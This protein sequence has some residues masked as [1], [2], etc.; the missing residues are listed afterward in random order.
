MHAP[1]LQVL[2]EK[3]QRLPLVPVMPEEPVLPLS[4]EAYHTLLKAGVLEDGDP[5]E[6]LEGF[7]V[8]K[9]TKGAHHAAIKRRF[10]RLINPFVPA[11]CFVDTQEAITATDSEPEPD[12]YIVRGPEEKYEQRNPGPGEVEVVVEI[13]ESSLRRDRGLK[14]RIYARAGVPTYWIIN[15]IDGCIEVFTQPGGEA[16]RRRYG[17][18][19]TYCAGDEVPLVIGGKEVGRISV[20]DILGLPQPKKKA[21]R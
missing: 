18:S 20:A 17:Q 4:I 11:S 12:V 10:L 13:S 6:L 14:K 3:G 21:R 5:V 7:L 16:P 15:L 8:P 19:A 2:D 1:R 9:M